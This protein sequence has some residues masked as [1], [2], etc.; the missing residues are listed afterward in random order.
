MEFSYPQDVSSCA[1]LTGYIY[2]F[3][4]ELKIT[5]YCSNYPIYRSKCCIT[6]QSKVINSKSLFLYQTLIEILHLIEGYSNFPEC[7][8]QAANCLFINNGCT[9]DTTKCA[10]TCKTCQVTTPPCVSCGSNGNCITVNYYGFEVQ[11]CK[12]TNNYIGYTC[13]RSNI[14]Y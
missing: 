2:S 8:D 14:I 5:D 11:Q 10:R 1:Q 9:L 6:C 4:V 7:A 13:S 3:S 12:C